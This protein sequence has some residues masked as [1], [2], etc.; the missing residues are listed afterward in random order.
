M[1]KNYE[2]ANS[3][4]RIGAVGRAQ[5]GSASGKKTA[6]FYEDASLADSDTPAAFALVSLLY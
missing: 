5:R 6:A 1:G 3:H 2:Q 4:N